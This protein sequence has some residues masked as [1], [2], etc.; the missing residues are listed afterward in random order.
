VIMLSTVRN[1]LA[2]V[3][4]IAEA[5]SRRILLTYCLHGLRVFVS[6][7]WTG[8]DL[9]RSDGAYHRWCALPR[10]TIIDLI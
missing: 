7:N 2:F 6:M 4:V 1:F 10:K 3:H 5:P 8:H 9:A